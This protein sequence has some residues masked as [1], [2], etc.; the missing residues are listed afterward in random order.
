MPLFL[1]G[2]INV[3][4]SPTDS[5]VDIRN[6]SDNIVIVYVDSKSVKL[7]VDQAVLFRCYTDKT[8]L[9]PNDKSRKIIELV[10]IN[11]RKQ[12]ML[13]NYVSV[14]RYPH[15]KRLESQIT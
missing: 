3:T 11:V 2:D 10:L 13:N 9:S 6:Y 12:K 14:M 15:I 4:K 7:D 1:M 8:K 5:I